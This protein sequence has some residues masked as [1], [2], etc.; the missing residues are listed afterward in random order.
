MNF[1]FVWRHHD[2]STV[3]FDHDGWCS[4]D[5]VKAA[6][7]NAMNCVAGSIPTIAPGIRVWLDQECRLLEV[8]GP[9]PSGSIESRQNA[10]SRLKGVRTRN[11]NLSTVRSSL[12]VDCRANALRGTLNLHHKAVGLSTRFAVKRAVIEFWRV[13]F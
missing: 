2:G 7:L 9:D 6:W 8:L 13:F 12:L 3:F 5:P 10:N 11:G 1:R 4:S